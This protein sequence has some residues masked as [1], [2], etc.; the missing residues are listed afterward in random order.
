LITS[1]AIATGIPVQDLIEEVGHDG[2][3]VIAGRKRGHNPYEIIT[4]LFE[5][6]FRVTEFPTS[7]PIE[8]DGFF[9]TWTQDISKILKNNKGVVIG[10]VNGNRHAAYWNGTSYVDP[11]GTIHNNEF[12]IESFYV[13]D[14][15][16]AAG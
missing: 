12:S 14:I 9:W 10:I 7:V 1:F 5:K 8:N 2:S 15:P 11:N 3:D 13:V 6:G 4:V 16:G